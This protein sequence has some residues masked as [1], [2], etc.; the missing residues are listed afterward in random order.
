MSNFLQAAKN[1][2]RRTPEPHQA[3]AWTM[4][5]GWLAPEQQAQF[6][7]TF[8][9]APAPKPS[10]PPSET[11]PLAG[12]LALIRAGEGN[13]SSINRGRAGDT[14]G[15]WTGLTSMTVA[16]VLQAQKLGKA[17]AV[18]AYQFIPSTLE[19]AVGRSRTPL[20]VPFSE[21]I[22]DRLAVE[23]IMGGWKRPKL[24]G[25]LKGSAVDLDAAQLELAQEWASIPGPNGRGFYDGDAG[26]NKASA[27][28]EAVRGLLQS[29]R[30]AIAKP[31]P[32]AKPAAKARPAPLYFP[33]TDNGDQADRTCF[34]STC[35]MLAELVKPGS[36]GTG[37]ADWTSY[38]KLV[39]RH[40]D[41]TNAAAQI[42]ALKELGIKARLVT[43]GNQ[44]LLDQQVER[45]GGIA[46]GWIHRGPLSR[47][48]PKC[49]GHWGLVFGADST[50]MMLHDPQGEPD[51]VAGGFIPGRSGRG[52]RISRANFAKRWEVQQASSG[53]L[54]STGHGWAVVV[55]GVGR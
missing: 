40:G 5:W 33:Q 35:A 51:L 22:Q 1:T 24:S 20:G 55:D 28:V 37:N 2:D 25:Y 42:A 13:Y 23:L 12:L 54:Y 45:W 15:G 47:P 30:E 44:A 21:L 18:G 46:V 17:F 19:T 31:A 16:E 41:T 4:A 52:V 53:W 32:A 38:F 49:I 48:D 39:A 8:R 27:K 10:P 11:S 43:A 6:L 3:A 36:V 9:A 50:H 7:E 34:T 26:G 14:P 29:A